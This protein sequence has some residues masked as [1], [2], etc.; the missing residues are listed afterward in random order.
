MGDFLP[1]RRLVTALVLISFI[2]SSYLIFTCYFL[3]PTSL[4]IRDLRQIVSYDLYTTFA[5]THNSQLTTHISHPYANQNY[6]VSLLKSTD[7][8]IDATP[9]MI[10]PHPSSLLTPWCKSLQESLPTIRYPSPLLGPWCDTMLKALPEVGPFD[11]SFPPSESIN[12]SDSPVIVDENEISGDGAGEP[13]LSSDESDADESTT[14]SDASSSSSRSTSPEPDLKLEVIPPTIQAARDHLAAARSKL[15]IPNPDDD[16][17]SKF[18]ASSKSK[19]SHVLITSRGKGV[20]GRRERRLIR[21]VLI[22]PR[23]VSRFFSTFH[24][25]IRMEM[26]KKAKRVDVST[27]CTV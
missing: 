23:E 3:R 17:K 9:Q 25:A 18:T 2:F 10:S 26:G 1:V 20:K 4:S 16:E 22:Q 27:V 11:A 21:S 13:T 12:E 7:V 5:S 6:Y 19:S 14:N 15:N 24:L 8:L